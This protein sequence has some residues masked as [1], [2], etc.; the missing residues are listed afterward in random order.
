[1]NSELLEAFDRALRQVDGARRTGAVTS[2]GEP[3]ADRLRELRDAL[4]RAR[5]AVV[6]HGSVDPDWLRDTIR[7]AAGWVAD[8]DLPLIA[9]LGAIA[10]AAQTHRASP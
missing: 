5:E 10:R 3:A 1:M 6:E 8:R 2:S 7:W 4:A 9:S